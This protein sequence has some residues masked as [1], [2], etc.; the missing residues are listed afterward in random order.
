LSKVYKNELINW[1]NDILK[2]NKIIRVFCDSHNSF[3][4]HSHEKKVEFKETDKKLKDI[5]KKSG[6]YHFEIGFSPSLK[7]TQE[8]NYF[9]SKDYIF[10]KKIETFNAYEGW[11]SMLF[12]AV[13]SKV[14]LVPDTNFI[15]YCVYTNYLKPTSLNYSIQIPRLVILEIES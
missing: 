14:I 3:I 9:L 10:G 7:F 8:G 1:I 15:K 12:D 13:R 2:N 6:L 11:L 5:V 4:I